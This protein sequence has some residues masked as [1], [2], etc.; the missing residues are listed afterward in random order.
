MQTQPLGKQRVQEIQT[1][2][3][4]L[5]PTWPG[6]SD[7]YSKEDQR[8]DFMAVFGTEQGKRVLSQIAFICE[9]QAVQPTHDQINNHGFL[10]AL[11]GMRW[12]WLEIQRC[13]A[14]SMEPT[15]EHTENYEGQNY[16][17]Q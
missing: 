4:A 13:F 12:V 15:I 11:N 5:S 7:N 10:A 2:L 8:K 6:I 14:G 16:Y 1:L 3:Q 9:G 17:E